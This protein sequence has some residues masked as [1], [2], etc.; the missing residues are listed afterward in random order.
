[1]LTVP[2]AWGAVPVDCN[3]FGF[4]GSVGND[5]DG[6]DQAILQIRGAFK[7]THA[8][9]TGKRHF[10]PALSLHD[11]PLTTGPLRGEFNHVRSQGTSECFTPDVG[12][13]LEH[14]IRLEIAQARTARNGPGDR[15]S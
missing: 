1:M 15:Y 9:R 3:T 13:L 11:Q 2:A 5:G 4:A 6:A 8:L 10:F 7:S 12:D 14:L